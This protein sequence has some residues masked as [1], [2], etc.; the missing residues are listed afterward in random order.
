MV[1]DSS[2]EISES[3]VLCGRIEVN[4]GRLIRLSYRVDL[5]RHPSSCRHDEDCMKGAPDSDGTKSILWKHLALGRS[6]NTVTPTWRHTND[7]C[8]R[9]FIE[10]GEQCLP[11]GAE[12]VCTEACARMR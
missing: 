9:S 1:S 5:G 6:H 4:I 10:R 11:I 8:I 12:D 2:E 3:H 7:N